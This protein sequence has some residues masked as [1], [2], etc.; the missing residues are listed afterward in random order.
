MMKEVR[1]PIFLLDRAQLVV[2]VLDANVSHVVKYLN[3]LIVSHLLLGCVA[4][5]KI[6]TEWP[7]AAQ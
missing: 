1:D 4:W 5:S 2:V 6:S 7:A 3:A